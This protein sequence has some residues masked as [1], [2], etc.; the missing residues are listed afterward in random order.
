MIPFEV[1]LSAMYLKGYEYINTLNIISDCII[2]NQCDRNCVEEIINTGRKIKF[3]STT[4]RGLSRSRNMAIANS[5]ADICI[6]C[7]NDVEYVESY[8][9][10]IINSFECN[11]E[12]D[13]IVFFIKRNDMSQPY[14]PTNRFLNYITSCKVFSPEIAFRRKRI[15]E[16]NI[17]FKIEFG[18]GSKYSMGEENMF[19]YDCLRAGLKIKYVPVMIA[20]LRKEQSTWFKGF[21]DKFFI[22]RGATF[23]GMSKILSIALILQYAIRKY[24]IYKYDM[25]MFKAL[26]YML[27][28][29][30]LYMNEVNNKN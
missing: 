18:A 30:R 4:E 11:P 9:N 23:Y 7:D 17:K 26:K 21:T 1:L 22:D 10:I 14:F 3:I 19:L 20:K 25:T 2:V 16:K 13:I 15:L 24:N 28:G 27:I 29:R 6:L 5:E 8:N 12:A